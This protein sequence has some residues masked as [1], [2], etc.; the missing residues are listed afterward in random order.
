MITLRE[1]LQSLDE[2]EELPHNWDTAQKLAVM[3]VLRDYLSPPSEPEVSRD[4]GREAE[5]VPADSEFLQAAFG[6]DP[7]RL[8]GLLDELMATLSVAMPRLY[9]AVMRRLREK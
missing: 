8:W 7:V 5:P 9:E 2:L 3:L 1:V 6:C 4:A